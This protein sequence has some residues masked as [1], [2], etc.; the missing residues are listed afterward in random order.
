MKHKKSKNIWRIIRHCWEQ[1]RAIVL[2]ML[3]RALTTSVISL[4]G[5]YL[6]KLII[7]EITGQN[8]LEV[9]AFIVVSAA[10]VILLCNIVGSNASAKVW[11]RIVM[12]RL[13]LVLQR[14][15]KLMGMDYQMTENP[16]VMDKLT[17]SNKAASDRISK[18][19]CAVSEIMGSLFHFVPNLLLTVAGYILILLQVSP[20]LICFVAFT[21]VLQYYCSQRINKIYLELEK[22]YAALERRREY[23]EE[24]MED[25]VFSKEIRI[26]RLSRL[27][28]KK[29]DRL[30]S[31]IARQ[32]IGGE[33]RVVPIRVFDVFINLIR[34]GAV[35]AFLYWQVTERG[36][37]VGDFSLYLT[38]VI[39]FSNTMVSMIQKITDLDRFSVLLEDFYV[40]LDI[41]ENSGG[42]ALPAGE[43]Q[44]IVLDRVTFTYPGSEK[45]VLREL[46][47]TVHPGE[48]LALVGIN[49]CGKTT[50]VKLLTGLYHPSSGGVRYGDR[51]VKDFDSGAWFGLFSTV[52]Q[53]VNIFAMTVAENVALCEAAEIDCGRVR[54]ALELAGLW[55]DVEKLKDTYDHQLQRIFS[56]E[57]TV[58]SGGQA[59]KLALA[60]A[61]YQDHSIV[62]LDEPTA[63]LDPLAEYNIY[64]R[65]NEI[66]GKKTAVYISHRLSSTRFCDRIAYM[67]D[68][69]ITELGTHEELMERNGS[70]A[71]MFRK[72]AH[73][74]QGGDGNEL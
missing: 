23:Y 4:V 60:R 2:V 51:D 58:L 25:A 26:Y 66:V 10:L 52:F 3:F 43:P 69:R 21:V 57:G 22:Q 47:L 53:D 9:L 56:E 13:K 20:L 45:P 15:R 73:Y 7:D 72:Q 67:E 31:E 36:M 62:I 71:E 16:D 64:C 17:R 50:L 1:D 28:M 41:P 61:L 46:S 49:G 33:K 6:T 70:Y 42:G 48:K 27:L 54:E 37:S 68:G 32:F 34:Y 18:S 24:Q 19:G 59:Q 65:F 12:L 30:W 11:Y 40:F 14:G 55:E 38:T 74:Y 5:V 35:S 44:P 39:A 63:S 29:Y 8:R